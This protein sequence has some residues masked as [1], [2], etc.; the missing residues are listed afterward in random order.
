MR[1][2]ATVAMV[3]LLPNDPGHC[4]YTNK[5]SFFA[6]LL[7]NRLIK[8]LSP[9]ASLFSPGEQT[10]GWCSCTWSAEMRASFFST[11]LWRR[12]WRRWS[13]KLQPF[14]TGDSRWT[15]YVQ[16]RGDHG[17]LDLFCDITHGVTMRNSLIL[18]NYY[19]NGTI[20]ACWKETTNL[21]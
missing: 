7:G 13:S 10:A 17:P 14:T 2:R 21:V 18:V 15:E 3:T 9:N 11:P 4:V 1:M 8:L 20:T 5:S 12:L 6:G 19:F 16:V